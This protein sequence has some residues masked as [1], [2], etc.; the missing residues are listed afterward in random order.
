MTE[1]LAKVPLRIALHGS[2][3][4]Y[5]KLLPLL[6]ELLPHLF[7]FL[8]RDRP[9]LDPLNNQI[10]HLSRQPPKPCARR[11]DLVRPPVSALARYH[12]R[13]HRP[14]VRI[15]QM[16]HQESHMAR[17]RVVFKS[18]GG[19]ASLEDVRE[20]DNSSFVQFHISEVLDRWRTV[21]SSVDVR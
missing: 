5:P 4:S 20:N 17:L 21:F 10:E 11:P 2:R 12:A 15:D 9:V 3:V 8:H 6:H 14:P 18:K 1:C 13:A 16:Q 7:P 19:N